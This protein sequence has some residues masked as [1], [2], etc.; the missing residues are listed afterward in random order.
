[1]C[2]DKPPRWVIKNLTETEESMRIRERYELAD[3]L[4]EQYRSPDREPSARISLGVEGQD[5]QQI[6]WAS[7]ANGPGGSVLEHAASLPV[8]VCR[9]IARHHAL[10]VGEILANL[11]HLAPLRPRWG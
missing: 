4:A 5:R 1:M 7:Y 6:V 8:P 11:D 9:H 3:E 10:L 2:L